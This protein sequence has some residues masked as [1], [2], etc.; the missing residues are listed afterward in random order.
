MQL[1]LVNGDSV[2]LQQVILNLIVNGV[3]AMRGTSSEHREIILI[4]STL[5]DFVQLSV[6]DYGVGFDAKLA[7]RLFDPFYTTKS[8]GTGMG[9]AICRTII[10]SHGGRIWAT[11][12]DDCGATFHM[13]LPTVKGAV[14]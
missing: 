9:L 4:T 7:D 13:C 8:M 12:N 11:S 2:A 1:P 10:E 5:G 14:T 6:R 3:Q